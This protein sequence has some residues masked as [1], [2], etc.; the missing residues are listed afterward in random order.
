LLMAM[1]MLVVVA[2][3]VVKWGKSKIFVPESNS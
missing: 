1:V 3:M 2:V